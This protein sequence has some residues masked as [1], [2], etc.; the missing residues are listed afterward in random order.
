MKKVPKRLFMYAGLFA[1]PLAHPVLLP[2]PFAP[3]LPYES[4]PRLARLQ[5]FFAERECPINKLAENFLLAAD[6]Q[7]LDWRLLPSIAL[8][9]SSGGKYYKNNNIF[10]WDSCRQRFPS[11]VEGIHH[12]AD[13][14]ANSD[15]YRD[16]NIDQLLRIYN[17]ERPEYPQMVKAVME[18]IGPRRGGLAST[19]N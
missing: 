18:T 8:I 1:T 5:E 11:V 12:V 2:L 3:N 19:V 16:K 10:G 6:S 7:A 4:D 9:E 17:P 15:T 14:L 13:K